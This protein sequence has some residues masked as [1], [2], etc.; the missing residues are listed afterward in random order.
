MNLDNID[1]QLTPTTVTFTISDNH[2]VLYIDNDST[3]FFTVP[4]LTSIVEVKIVGGQGGSGGNVPDLHQNENG[5]WSYGCPYNPG[6]GGG[7]GQGGTFASQN[8]AYTRR[9]Y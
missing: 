2:G 3:V 9:C 4:P 1:D 8:Y 6:S 5:V 7:G